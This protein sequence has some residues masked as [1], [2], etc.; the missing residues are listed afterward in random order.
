MFGVSVGIMDGAGGAGAVGDYVSIATTTVGAGGAA[1]VTFSSIPS[2]Y[3]HLQIRAISKFVTV[4]NSDNYGIIQFNSDGNYL[5]YSAHLLY[6]TASG[7][8]AAGATAI[9]ADATYPGAVS[10]ES[11]FSGASQT[12]VFGVQV[13]DIL[14]YTN[15][16]KNK[17]IRSLSGWDG[18]GTGWVQYTSGTWLN[19]AAITSITLCE[20]NTTRNFAQYTQFALYGIKG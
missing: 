2:T 9:I 7:G 15:T 3:K 10:F 20:K 17:T 1:S 14:D 6:A 11:P 13:T 18:N 19:T 4:S 8:G 16:N 12:N 5:N